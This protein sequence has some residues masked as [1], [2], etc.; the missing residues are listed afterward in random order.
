MREEKFFKEKV[1][2]KEKQSVLVKF[3]RGSL[4]R[5]I[6]WRI[7]LV[8]RRLWMKMMKTCLMITKRKK[9]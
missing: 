3:A 1:S 8:L 5:K 7:P 6:E 2:K 4:S 9:G